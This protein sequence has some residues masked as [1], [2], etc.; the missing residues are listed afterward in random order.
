MSFKIRPDGY[1][2]IDPTDCLLHPL[3]LQFN[4]FGE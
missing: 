2:V 4:L 3:G 1:N